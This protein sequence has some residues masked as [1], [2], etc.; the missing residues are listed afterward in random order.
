V[1]RAGI[2]QYWGAGGKA[3]VAGKCKLW[4]FSPE[5]VDRAFA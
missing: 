3:H 4:G 5:V 2:R 1:L